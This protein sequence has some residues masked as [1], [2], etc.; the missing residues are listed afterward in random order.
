VRPLIHREAL[1]AALFWPG[2]TA[3]ALGEAALA[4]RTRNTRDATS[5][6]RTGRLLFVTFSLTVAAAF[7]LSRPRVAALPDGAWPWLITG[8]ALT[9]AGLLLRLWSI[10]TLGR[11]FQC[12]VMVH[13]NQSVIDTGPYRHIRHPSYTGMLLITLGLGVALGNWL[14]VAVCVALPLA[15][16]LTRISVE[17]AVLE[18]ELGEP[19]RRYEARTHRLVPGVW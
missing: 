15:G 5:D 14:S 6:R 13:E 10:G 1:A 11:Y 9:W 2:I 17:E 3:W 16:L 18:R 12:T 4:W 19:Y 8:V 7:A